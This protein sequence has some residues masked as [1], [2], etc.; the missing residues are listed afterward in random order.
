MLNHKIYTIGHSNIDSGK[1]IE[2]LKHHGIE[3]VV[4]VRSAPYSR[5]AVWFNRESIRKELEG[6][7]INYIYM[8]NMLG[9]RP[10]KFSAEDKATRIKGA[11][12]DAIYKKIMKNESYREG[13]SKLIEISGRMR[14]AIMCSEEDPQSCHRHILIAQTL[15]GAGINVLHIRGSCDVEQAKE[16]VHQA[17]LLEC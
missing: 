7:G 6:N 17:A 13:I 2:I 14:T 3:A 12:S 16:R 10:K 1:F 9:G 15:L 5:Y 11:S 8:G 4:D